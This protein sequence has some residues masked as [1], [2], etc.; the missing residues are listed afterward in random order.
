MDWSTEAARFP[1]SNM[2]IDGKEFPTKIGELD[3]SELKFYPDNPRVYTSIY[4]AGD[5]PDQKTIEEHM[6]VLP[7]VAKLKREIAHHQGLLDPVIVR[8]KTFDVLEGN[9]RL[10]AYRLLRGK[11]KYQK[12]R[13]VILPADIHENYIFA[14]LG[15]IHIN[16]K[17]PWAA[18]EKARYLQR[19]EGKRGSL[20]TLSKQIGLT[21]AEGRKMV[22][23]IEL[24]HKHGDT[25]HDHFSYYLAY[26]GNRAAQA[27]AKEYPK[28]EKI[29]ATEIKNGTFVKAT[30]FRDALTPVC[31]DRTALKKLLS[32]KFDLSVALDFLEQK[33]STTE[34]GKKVQ[35]AKLAIAKI[36]RD[37]LKELKTPQLN[38]VERDL[39]IIKRT[40]DSLLK[41]I[42]SIKT[43][44]VADD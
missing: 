3:Q 26:L 20:A 13:C 12:M 40:S 7:H 10:A 4:D 25:Q 1:D 35:N 39:R 22:T 43:H 34:A 44:E 28:L 18:H 30:E 9:S 19:E 23:S 36:E 6:C 31:K 41:I 14:Y 27:A 24:M 17:T 29:V 21:P 37:D 33:G 11:R 42:K 32:K 16:G 15:Q 8:D 38:K 2:S 5:E